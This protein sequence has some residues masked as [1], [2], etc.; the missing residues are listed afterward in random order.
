MLISTHSNSQSL[1]E[2][3]NNP[4]LNYFQIQEQINNNKALLDSANEK[5]LKF[6]MRWQWFWSSR[7]DE[8]GSVSAYGEAMKDFSNN[9]K[10]DKTVSESWQN[11]GPNYN[12]LTHIDYWYHWVYKH[13]GRV[14]SIWV[15]PTDTSEIYIGSNSAGLWKTNDAFDEKSFRV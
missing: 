12:N 4:D 10:V 9:Y 8:S 11:L 14:Q 6:Y 3:F 1:G 7:V 15:N 5:E 2:I 13:L